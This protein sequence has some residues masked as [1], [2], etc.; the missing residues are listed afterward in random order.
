MQAG[1]CHRVLDSGPD[2]GPREDAGL[3][4][5]GAFLAKAFVARLPLHVHTTIL[6]AVVLFGGAV[7]MLPAYADQVLHVGAHGLGMLRAAPAIGSI[8]MALTLAMRP[9]MKNGSRAI[10]SQ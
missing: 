4:Q 2:T 10:T 8:V 9:M 5:T 1:R 6:D 7:A 3:C